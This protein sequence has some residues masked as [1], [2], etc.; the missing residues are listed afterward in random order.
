MLE[1]LFCNAR[2]GTIIGSLNKAWSRGFHIMIKQ[3]RNLNLVI[4]IALC[5]S[6]CGK[7]EGPAD[8]P[9]AD[10]VFTN[11][12]IFTVDA[13]RSWA[14][15]VAVSDGRITYVGSTA[16]ANQHI[17]ANTTVVDLNGR[18]MMP[19]FQDSHIHPIGAGIEA[20]AC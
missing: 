13:D 6:A 4:A 2:Q 9:G 10:A 7:T 19:S 14:E 20:S 18:M 8:A 5:T 3:I 1:K 16:G 17:G 12:R 15:A 11:G